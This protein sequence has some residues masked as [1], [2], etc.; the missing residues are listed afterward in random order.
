MHE[1]CTKVNPDPGNLYRCTF[2]DG[3]PCGFTPTYNPANFHLI[4]QIYQGKDTHIKTTDHTL[5]TLLGHYYA[6]DFYN[7][8]KNELQTTEHVRI[9]SNFF[10]PTRGTCV[11]FSYYMTGQVNNESLNFYIKSGDQDIV[12]PSWAA[13][14]DLGPFWYSHR[15]TVSSELKWKIG[16]DVNT[17][18]SDKGLIAIDDVIVELDKP[19]PPKCICDFEVCNLGYE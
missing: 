15:M 1:P 11:T 13:T 3:H 19:C 12:R 6:L 10:R 8:E 4:W 2:E 17:Y 14:G 7:M 9:F 5:K 18:E 16:F